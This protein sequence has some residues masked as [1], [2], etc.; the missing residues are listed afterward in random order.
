MERS[1][2][3]SLQSI[4]S[5]FFF[6]RLGHVHTPLEMSL[7]IASIC[8]FNLAGISYRTVNGMWMPSFRR[9]PIM[10]LCIAVTMS[11]NH[12][13]L[14][15][16]YLLHTCSTLSSITDD[17][18]TPSNNQPPYSQGLSRSAVIHSLAGWSRH[19]LPCTASLS[20]MTKQYTYIWW[21]RTNLDEV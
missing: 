21:L 5:P 1:S 9:P 18:A 11:D 20:V 12:H 4:I 13:Q 6:S 7:L 10:L 16:V 15:A 19:R 14:T 8:H 2:V 17:D 3:W